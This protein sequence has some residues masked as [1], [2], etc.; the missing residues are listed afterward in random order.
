MRPF[1]TPPPSLFDTDPLEISRFGVRLANENQT[2]YPMENQ[3][4]CVIKRPMEIK[5]N[6]NQTKLKSND[7]REIK[8]KQFPKRKTFPKRFRKYNQTANGN[9]TKKK[10]NNQREIKSKR[11]PKHKTFPKSFRQYNQTPNEKSIPNR[12]MKRKAF[13]KSFRKYNQKP[14]GKQ[15]KKKSNNQREIKHKRFVNTIKHP[16]RNQSKKTFS[17]SWRYED[18]DE[19]EDIASF[20]FALF[21]RRVERIIQLCVVQVSHWPNACT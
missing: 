1:C 10:S 8:P 9:Q 2:F 16:M 7:Q 21:K 14:N 20:S 11:F 12:F 4:A 19:K 3:T 18:H 5:Q 13:R 6:G 15:T 17:K